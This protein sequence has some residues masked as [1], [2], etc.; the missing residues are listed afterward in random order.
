[1]DE[2]AF[3]W[4]DAELVLP[5]DARVVLCRF[6]DGSITARRC[7][8]DFNGNRQWSGGWYSDAPA[9]TH[10]LRAPEPPEPCATK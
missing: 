3:G 4:V 7:G 1:M 6:A 8:W 5:A 2:R 10:W 9:P